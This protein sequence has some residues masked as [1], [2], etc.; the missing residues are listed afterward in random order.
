MIGIP[1]GEKGTGRE[2][3]VRKTIEEKFTGLKKDLILQLKWIHSA[4]TKT[5]I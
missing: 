5:S 4:H 3:I 2:E 1:E